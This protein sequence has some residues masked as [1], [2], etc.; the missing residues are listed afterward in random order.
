MNETSTPQKLLLDRRLTRAI[1]EVVC[2]QMREHV[3]TLAPIFRPRSIFG[4]HIQGI[5]KEAG[6]NADQAFKE[7]QASYDAI[8]LTRPF[9]LPKELK[10][11]LMQ[12]TSTVELSP[13]EYA[14]QVGANGAQKTVQITRPFKWILTYSTYS[15]RRLKQLLT[16]L[17]RNDDELQ[18]AVLHYLVMSIVIAKQPG[19]RAIFE[20][21]HFP[22]VTGRLPGFGEL[23]VTY[24]ESSI[25]TRLPDDALVA[26]STDLSGKDAFEEI[27]NLDDIDKLRDP[28]KERLME[29]RQS[30]R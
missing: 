2:G 11:P 26:E 23:P 15:P 12:M 4:D 7:L 8:A 14:H 28:L 13:T 21:I 20:A 10:A 3:A 5:G 25:S 22:L 29:I 27:V 24:V 6:K 19:L 18:Q 9:N 30:L 16:D 17:N 1:G